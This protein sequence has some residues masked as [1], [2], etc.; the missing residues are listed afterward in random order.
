MRRNDVMNWLEHHPRCVHGDARRL[1]YCCDIEVRKHAEEDA[2]M[3]A[4]SIVEEQK[5]VWEHSWGFHASEAF[6]AREICHKFALKMRELEPEV[7]EGDEEE[8]AGEGVMAAFEP[9]ARPILC[10]WIHD[11]ACEEEHHVWQDIVRFTDKRAIALEREGKLSREL[12]WEGSHPYTETAAR[13]AGI[14]ASDCERRA[15]LHG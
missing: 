9:E 4:K 8:L 6:V 12:S 10:K 7:P 15:H 3:R 5:E 13:V 1:L 11:L 14:L 2:W